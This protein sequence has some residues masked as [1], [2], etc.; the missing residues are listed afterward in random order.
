MEFKLKAIEKEE[1]EA[2]K[3]NKVK[4]ITIIT[5][6]GVS[7]ILLLISVIKMNLSDSDGLGG[8]FMLFYVFLPVFIGGGILLLRS[9]QIG[10]EI[11]NSFKVAAYDFHQC[12]A[13]IGERTLLKSSKFFTKLALQMYNALA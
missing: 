11:R 5:W 1:Q 10:S 4:K 13:A 2:A 12:W 8:F 9:S 3:K 7:A 6:L